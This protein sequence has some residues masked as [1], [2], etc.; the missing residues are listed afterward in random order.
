MEKSISLKSVKLFFITKKE[1]Q[2]N[3]NICYFKLSKKD[4]KTFNNISKVEN[5]HL[6]WFATQKKDT[7]LKAK[8]KFVDEYEFNNDDMYTC[9]IELK[10]YSIDTDNGDNLIGYYVSKVTNINVVENKA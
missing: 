1:N 9:D 10:S 2:Y 8:V 7:I 5:A 6:P 4:S 3:D